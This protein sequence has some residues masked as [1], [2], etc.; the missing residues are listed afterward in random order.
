MKFPIFTALCMSVVIGSLEAQYE[1]TW[2]YSAG[3]SN[4]KFIG[5]LGTVTSPGG[6]GC[7]LSKDCDLV[8]QFHCCDGQ[9][10][11]WRLHSV[12]ESNSH[13]HTDLYVYV[14]T[15]PS[16][17]SVGHLVPYDV[18]Y[19]YSSTGPPHSD[20]VCVNIKLSNGTELRC[21][22]DE[23]YRVDSINQHYKGSVARTKQYGYRGIQWHSLGDVMY[24]LA[25]DPAKEKKLYRYRIDHP[26]YLHV[27]MVNRSKS[28]NSMTIASY[29]H[30]TIA[31][32]VF[33]NP[34]NHYDNKPVD[35]AYNESI[36]LL[37]ALSPTKITPHDV[38][39]SVPP[40]T[41]SM[42]T[43]TKPASA[44]GSS[45]RGS[46]PSS[47]TTAGAAS[48]SSGFMYFITFLLIILIILVAVRIAMPFVRKPPL[49]DSSQVSPLAAPVEAK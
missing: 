1:I 2:E 21:L 43:Q 17:A 39:F 34:I 46:Q 24:P 35:M 29:L 25:G 9:M 4:S 18:P 13:N 12:K 30:N 15:S 33:A 31:E 49:Q 44:M 7:F 26:A 11:E 14:T 27:I 19:L 8:V 37:P 6:T 10:L 45:S 36:K 32:A 22:D 42:S 47:A 38:T 23:A 5:A 48:S 28:D 40:T 3:S 41:P 16:V 20:E